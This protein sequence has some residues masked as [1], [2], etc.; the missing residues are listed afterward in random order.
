MKILLFS[1]CISFMCL[2]SSGC[3]SYLSYIASEDELCRTRIMN[4]GD[5]TAMKQLSL[6]VPP[7][8]AIRS[9]VKEGM[10]GLAIDFSSL[11]V[12]KEHPWRQLAAA[13]GDAA[14]GYGLYLAIDELTID[15]SHHTTINNTQNNSN[16]TVNNN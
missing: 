12:I 13:I 7:R 11:D 2:Y 16:S 6:G 10:A 8:R 5:A 1:I 15:N 3:L 9:V 14:I 4:S